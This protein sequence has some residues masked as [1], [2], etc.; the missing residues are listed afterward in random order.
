VRRDGQ[1][2]RQ[3]LRVNKGEGGRAADGGE[4]GG[5]FAGPEE[6]RVRRQRD[7]A[8]GHGE[9]GVPQ[10]AV[11]VPDVGCEHDGGREPRVEAQR[12]GEPEQAKGRDA[13]AHAGPDAGEG[14]GVVRDEQQELVEV[15]GQRAVRHAELP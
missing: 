3:V 14:D 11:E 15:G 6:R 4:Q 8:D 7:G 2:E 13:G 9:A 5:A 12:A 1:H 10:D